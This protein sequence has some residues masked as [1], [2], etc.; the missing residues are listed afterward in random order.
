MLLN[1]DV[2]MK[3]T[4]FQHLHPEDAGL[5]A[6]LHPAASFNH[7]DDV[8]DRRDLALDEKRAI[9]AAWASDACAVE[10]APAVRRAPG[11]RCPVPVDDI[12]EA[13]R[14]LDRQACTTESVGACPKQGRD[15]RIALAHF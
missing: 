2:A 4:A 8:I 14:R 1:E 10:A 9:L 15:E 5:D 12:L 3:V 7:P 6:L 11:G 13:L